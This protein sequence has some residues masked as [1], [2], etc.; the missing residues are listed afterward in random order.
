MRRDSW[1]TKEIVVT[2]G[3]ASRAHWRVEKRTSITPDIVTRLKRSGVVCVV[4]QGV[5][6]DALSTDADFEKAGARALALHA[7]KLLPAAMCSVS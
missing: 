3:V 6:P 7:T 1:Q 5:G 2:Y 4:E